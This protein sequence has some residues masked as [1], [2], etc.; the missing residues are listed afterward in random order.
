MANT[1][2]PQAMVRCLRQTLADVVAFSMKAQGYHWNVLGEN[3]QQYHDLFGTIYADVA[4]SV[5]PIAENILKVGSYSPYHIQDLAAMTRIVPV[6]Q[7]QSCQGM[8]ADLLASNE[9]VLTSLYECFDQ[10]SRSN[11]QGI[12]DFAAGRIDMHQKWSWQLK[13][14]A[15]LFRDVMAD[16]GGMGMKED[17]V[18]RVQEIKGWLQ[19]K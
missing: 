12:A 19:E 4:G 1:T 16:D 9:V 17:L 5:D 13:Q 8:A 14:S 18:Q 15:G 11:Q 6:P 2:E 3:F 7:P 10:A